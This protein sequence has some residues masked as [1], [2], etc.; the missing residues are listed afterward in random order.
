MRVT[1]RLEQ[2]RRRTPR[3][4]PLAPA[5]RVGNNARPTPRMILP[6]GR[7]VH[8]MHVSSDALVRRIAFLP[9]FVLGIGCAAYYF[10]TGDLLGTGVALMLSA[11]AFGTIVPSAPIAGGFAVGAGVPIAWTGAQLL[12]IFIA[13]P[14]DPNAAATLLGFL[15][16]LTGALVAAGLAHLF[17]PRTPGPRR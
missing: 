15:P 8:R 12:E 9:A 13:F 10:E 6:L 17:R 16:A 3:L 1:I 11:F 7:R 14:P 2:E 4:G 5:W